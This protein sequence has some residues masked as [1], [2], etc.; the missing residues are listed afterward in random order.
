MT[1]YGD[2]DAL[3]S[4]GKEVAV[5]RNV[6]QPDPSASVQPRVAVRERRQRVDRVVVLPEV[7]AVF[8]V[9]GR[10]LGTFLGCVVHR[11]SLRRCD[12]GGVDGLGEQSLVAVGFL[13]EISGHTRVRVP[14]AVRY[15]V[16]PA[17]RE[18]DSATY[19]PRDIVL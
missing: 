5:G 12:L 13:V 14:L 15:F 11:R 9:R 2:E 7:A 18:R 19:K 16:R 6:E 10:H 4:D 8:E 17:H 1:A 3:R